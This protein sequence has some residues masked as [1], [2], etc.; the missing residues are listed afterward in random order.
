M[1]YGIR[2]VSL[3]WSNSLTGNFCSDQEI[4][5]TFFIFELQF[6]IFNKNVCGRNILCHLHS[7]LLLC[8]A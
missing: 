2:M 4:F 6:E 1:S 5:D 7:E 8:Y 3:I